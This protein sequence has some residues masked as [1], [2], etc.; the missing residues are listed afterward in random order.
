MHA[1]PIHKHLLDVLPL[2]D[3]FVDEWRLAPLELVEVCSGNDLV[4]PGKCPE[5]TV[6]EVYVLQAGVLQ[7]RESEWHKLERIL[8]SHLVLLESKHVV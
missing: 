3:V 5:F 1:L 2:D 6:L 4:S 7:V 8:Q